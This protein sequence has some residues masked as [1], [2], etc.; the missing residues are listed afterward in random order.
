MRILVVDDSRSIRQLVGECL[1]DLGHQVDFAEDGDQC[2]KIIK[3]SPVDLILMDV[4]MPG[5][6]GMQ[7]TRAI[8]ELKD[9]DWFPII[10]LTSHGDDESFVDGIMAGGDAYLQKPLNPLRLQYTIMTMERIYVMRQKLQ[11]TQSELS[12]A[13]QQL[14]HLA[15]FDELTGLAN[16][17]HFD[18]TLE[19]Q[20]ALSWRSKSPLSLILCDIDYFKFY[21]DTYGHQ[22][23]D[24]CLA[25]VAEVI[26]KESRRSCDLACRYGGEEFTVILP[27]TDRIGAIRVAERIRL[28]VFE[29]QI[30]HSGSKVAACVSLSLGTATFQ[31]QFKLPTELTLSA[32]LALYQAKQMGRNRVEAAV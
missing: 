5:L 1:K 15:M 10:F 32:D 9:P 7:T 28:A 4:E 17:R 13:N 18:Q 21:N 26:G 2:M 31:G 11:Q 20:F 30:P 19:M 22:Q 3:Q 27:N 16:R 24:N 8:R 6:N 12:F 25:A 23:G 29:Q 14:Q